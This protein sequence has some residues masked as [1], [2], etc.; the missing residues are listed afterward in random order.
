MLLSLTRGVGSPIAF[1]SVDDHV[2]SDLP[3][4]LDALLGVLPPLRAWRLASLVLALLP[5]TTSE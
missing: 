5:Q 4:K 3:G 2:S 1:Q